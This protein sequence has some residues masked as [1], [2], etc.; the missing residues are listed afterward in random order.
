MKISFFVPGIPRPGGS[1]TGQTITRKDGSL[2]M[3]PKTHKPVVVIRDAGKYTKT[4][5]STVSSF[6]LMAYRGILLTGPVYLYAVFV[7][8]YRK[9]DYGTGRNAGVLK[10]KAPHYHIS[11]PDRG[12]LM[13]A[14]EDA[15]T[16]IIWHD[17]SQSCVSL[18]KK[19]Y[20]EKPGVHIEIE[21]LSERNRD[22]NDEQDLFAGA[23]VDGSVSTR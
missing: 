10:A 3:N 15:L 14:L 13:R 8:P 21:T 18:G 16:G 4:W 22:E 6:A 20:G 9:G 12:K 17:D 11:K 23:A 1:K 2:V 19:I 5:Q 7:M